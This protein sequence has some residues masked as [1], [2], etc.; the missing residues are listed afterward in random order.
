M[1]L[2][3]KAIDP[4][5]LVSIGA[6]GFYSTTCDR[7]P[8]SL[9][10]SESSFFCI[11]FSLTLLL[12]LPVRTARNQWRSLFF[13]A[14]VVFFTLLLIFILLLVSKVLFLFLS[15]LFYPAP[16]CP[17]P[18]FSPPCTW[19]CWRSLSTPA[20]YPCCTAA[21]KFSTRNRLVEDDGMLCGSVL[22]SQRGK[23]LGDAAMYGAGT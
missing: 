19:L 17:S 15:P 20:P 5:H 14:V 10:H 12:F 6:E 21:L 16:L 23:G 13:F 11:F 7:C 2:W 22:K 3:L 18:L 1:A 8:P 9:S 4:N